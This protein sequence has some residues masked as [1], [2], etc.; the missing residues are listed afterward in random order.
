VTAKDAQGIEQTGT[1]R[2]QTVDVICCSKPVVDDYSKN[3]NAVDSLNVQTCWESL[4]IA[5]NKFSSESWIKSSRVGKFA[6]IETRITGSG[7]CCKWILYSRPHWSQH[8]FMALVTQI[9]IMYKAHISL[10]TIARGN[11]T[12]HSMSLCSELSYD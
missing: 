11:F 7:R 5:L 12:K 2:A 9:I 8:C 10:L 3:S 4:M 1:R 6:D